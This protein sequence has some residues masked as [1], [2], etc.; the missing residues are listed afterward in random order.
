MS[1]DFWLEKKVD[2]TVVT[3]TDWT[4]YTHNCNQ[5][6]RD[7]GL[8]EWPYEVDG[9]SARKLGRR[10]Q[11]V[12]RALDADPGR[13][14]AMNPPNGWGDYEG[15]LRVLYRVQSACAMFPSAKVRVSA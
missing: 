12:L 3:L 8:P 4:N 5:M 14:R 1:W 6:V 13:F 15:L 11:S 9:W 10:L 7:A 2:G